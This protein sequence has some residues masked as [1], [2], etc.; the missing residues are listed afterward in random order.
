MLKLSN[1]TDRLEIIRRIIK[2]RLN[3]ECT[4]QAIE[5]YIKQNNLRESYRKRRKAFKDA[6]I[7]I[8]SINKTIDT[9]KATGMSVEADK[10]QTEEYV[11]YRVRIPFTKAS[12]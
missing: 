12:V 7:F 8:N 6:R 3:V 9:M 10:T 5:E 4:E 11:E 2:Y 1:K